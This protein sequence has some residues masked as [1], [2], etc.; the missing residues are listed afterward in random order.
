MIASYHRVV[1]P[2]V[3]DAAVAASAPIYY[4]GARGYQIDLTHV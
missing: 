2:E 1:L 3:F 4:I